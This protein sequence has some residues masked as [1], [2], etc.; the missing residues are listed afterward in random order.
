MSDLFQA[1]FRVE[2]GKRGL[3]I[4]GIPL[5]MIAVP[6]VAN[7]GDNVPLGL[8]MI[9]AFWGVLALGLPYLGVRAAMKNP[10]FSHEVQYTFSGAGIDIVAEHSNSHMDW[11][12]VTG[13]RETKNF[14]LLI[15]IRS[16]VLPLPK[17]CF[18]AGDLDRIKEMLRSGVAGKVKLK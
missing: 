14:I 7:P 12:L 4:V 10:N 2:L 8:T 6:F 13:A 1:L 17:R 15:V 9:G 5:L 3:L 11:T 16:T 18:Q